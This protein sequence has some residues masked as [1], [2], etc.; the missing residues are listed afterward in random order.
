[1]AEIRLPSGSIIT[2]FPIPPAG[3][4]P[5][6]ADEVAL[7]QYGLPPRPAGNAAQAELWRRVVGIPTQYL[8]PTFERSEDKQ[9]GP[10]R[11]LVGTEGS[12]N[13]SG[14]VAYVTP[15]NQFRS[16]AAEW[17]VPAVGPESNDGGNYYSSFWIGIDGDSTNGVHSPDVFQ[18]GVGCD[19]VRNASGVYLW[20]EW[21]P[22]NEVRITNFPVSIGHTLSCLLTV[23][24]NTEGK[25]FLRNQTTGAATA[26]QITAP[27][28]TTLVGNSAEWIAE[29]P[30]VGGALT[31]LA[32]FSPIMFTACAANTNLGQTLRPIDGDNINM[33]DGVVILAT[34]FIP[35]ADTVDCIYTGPVPISPVALPGRIAA[36]AG[37]VLYVKK[38]G[39]T[40]FG[41]EK[42]TT[43]KSLLWKAIAS[44]HLTPQAT[45]G[46]RRGRSM[47]FGWG[48]KKTR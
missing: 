14:A 16:I 31:K 22:E 27:N 39:L 12:D 5:L 1:M 34:G 8:K 3:F 25:V 43:F 29:R 38:D 18:A 6:T 37:D 48:L 33:S 35:A 23:I 10:R 32:V 46:S 20:W 19:V 21:Y 4:N 13:W 7:R 47:Q 24:S 9:H 26:F 30:Q 36:L 15:G 2:A 45:Y 11:V 28:R 42:R 40:A 41:F 44:R 17:T